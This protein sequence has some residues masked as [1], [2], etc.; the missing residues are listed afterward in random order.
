MSKKKIEKEKEVVRLMIKLY[1]HKRLKLPYIPE[2]YA[3]LTEYA[4]R[5]LDMCKFGN[6]KTSC[7]KCPIHCYKKDKREEI[8]EIMR[9]AGPRMIFYAPTAAIKHLFGR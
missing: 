9:W 5:R 4:I 8:R 3:E 2:K 7:K 1:C 6:A